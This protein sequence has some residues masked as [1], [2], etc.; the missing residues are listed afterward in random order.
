MK[1]LLL[2]SLLTLFCLLKGDEA[3]LD[4]TKE[5]TDTLVDSPPT[6]EKHDEIRQKIVKTIS[7]ELLEIKNL[8]N[9]QQKI[10]HK[11]LKKDN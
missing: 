4:S 5:L 2:I 9:I 8:Q 11:E 1:R 3:I 10:N 6:I 7:L